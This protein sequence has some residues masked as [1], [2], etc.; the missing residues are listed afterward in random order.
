MTTPSVIVTPTLDG[1]HTLFVPEL[2]EHYHSTYGAVQESE[3]V[4][5]KQGLL[6][7][8]EEVDPVEVFEVGFGTGLNALLAL[9]TAKAQRREVRY[10]AV[11][12]HPL[13]REV[14]ERLNYPE[15]LSDPDAGKWFRKIHEAPWE[16]PCR[17]EQHFRLTKIEGDLRLLPILESAFQIVFFDA[18][19]PDVQPHLWSREIFGKMF[20]ILRPGGILVTYSCKGEVKRALKEAGF[21][22]EKLPGPPGKREILRAWKS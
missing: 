9:F 6:A 1:S 5:I 14:W 13:G 7:V 17:I 18:F 8:G 12:L 21:T 16:D 4:F 11:E 3:Y 19:S 2:N 22:T 20:R 15:V 10:T